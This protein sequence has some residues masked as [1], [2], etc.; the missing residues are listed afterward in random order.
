MV[1]TNNNDPMKGFWSKQDVY[2]KGILIVALVGIASVFLN[3]I[4]QIP[5]INSDYGKIALA[6]F[7]GIIIV[8]FISKLSN[9]TKLYIQTT[10]G[11]IALFFVG[12]VFFGYKQKL[13]ELQA[14]TSELGSFA[15]GLAD[16][17]LQSFSPQFGFYLSLLVAVALV[18]LCIYKMKVSFEKAQFSKALKIV[19]AVAVVILLLVFIVPQGI[20]KAKSWQEE[21]EQKAQAALE[22]K[23]S[24]IDENF[25]KLVTK[26]SQGIEARSEPYQ[27]TDY[28]KAIKQ[29]I[30]D[31]STV[32]VAWV[33]SI[34][35]TDDTIRLFRLDYAQNDIF[36]ENKQIKADFIDSLKTAVKIL[37]SEKKYDIIFITAFEG[38]KG[39]AEEDVGKK[40]VGSIFINI[41]KVNDKTDFTY[42]VRSGSG[43]F[44]SY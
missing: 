16:M 5:G 27:S 1:S 44:A 8:G 26:L 10:F 6:A 3:W 29:R 25:N 18:G 37:V 2:S 35:Y 13:N 23:Q 28:V 21:R 4:G 43:I 30:N 39:S 11:L 17:A 33:N 41:A 31:Q 36:N 24:N 12:Y 14:Q 20:E 32:D 42:V 9:K 19:G 34:K 22:Q 38:S 7:V 40:Q 15:G